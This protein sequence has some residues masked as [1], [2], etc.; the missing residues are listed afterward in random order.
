MMMQQG[1]PMLEESFTYARAAAT[2]GMP[3]V[4]ANV[5]NHAIGQI[6]NAPQILEQTL[7]MARLAAPWAA[8][9]DPVG[10]GWNLV[11]QGRP[12]EGI[13]LMSLAWPTPLFPEQWDAI[14]TAAASKSVQLDEIV[15]KARSTSATLESEAAVS[16]AAI[17]KSQNDT[18]TAAKQAGLL[19]TTV[20][21]D[22]TNSLYKSD[23][24]RNADESKTA[25][26][27][28]L[29]VLGLAATLAVLPVLSHYLG[30]GPKYST[31]TLLGAHLA[32]T[33]ALATFAGVLLAR[34]RSRDVA[35]Q[36]SHDLST[37]MGTMI[38]YSN[39][40]SN[41]AEKERFMMTMGQL[42]LQAHLAGGSSSGGGDES[43]SGAVALAN[44]L[45]PAPPN[46][47]NAPET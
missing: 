7:E 19:V 27:T 31:T 37:A 47:A 2:R 41:P 28:G 6:A 17:E 22:A 14:A 5:F 33:A 16:I 39:Q 23:A 1:M 25:W 34:A 9:I 36:R 24:K 12:A 43:L 13:R 4:A 3:W 44:L 45:R 32:S 8:G 30:Q 42:V 29:A 11:A 35:S 40:I 15:A 26:L 20:V 38:G 21:S 10:Q 18:E 46:A